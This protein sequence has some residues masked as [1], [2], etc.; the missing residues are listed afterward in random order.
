MP[1]KNYLR[2]R[3]KEYKILEREKKEGNIA[4]RSAGSH[5]PIDII[6]IN[7]KDKVIKLIQSKPNNMSINKKQKLINNNKDLNGYFLVS[8]S[9]E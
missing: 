3:R 8:F 4:V 5:S 9:V 1:N 2:G 6:S 7:I